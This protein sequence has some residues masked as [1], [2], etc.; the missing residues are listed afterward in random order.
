MPKPKTGTAELFSLMPCS[1]DTTSTVMPGVVVAAAE[2]RTHG[3]STSPSNNA[4]ER[5]SSTSRRKFA[6]IG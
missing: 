4:V 2:G 3:R 5:Q 6:D 1:G